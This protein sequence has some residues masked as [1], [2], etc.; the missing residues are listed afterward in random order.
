MTVRIGDTVAVHHR[1]DDERPAEV[2]ET[3]RRVL[4]RTTAR[5]PWPR[6]FGH[7]DATQPEPRA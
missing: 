5:K 6:W 1:R 7:T 2:A 4:T 3:R